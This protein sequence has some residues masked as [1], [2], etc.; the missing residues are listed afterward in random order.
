MRNK[1]IGGIVFVSLGLLLI[2]AAFWITARNI[3]ED[4]AANK[5]SASVLQEIQEEL[6]AQS[7]SE[8]A[9]DGDDKDS[10]GSGL[11]QGEGNFPAGDS[12]NENDI[13]QIE[14]P[15]Y[16]KNPDMEMPTLELKGKDYIG[17]LEMP[18]LGI[19][20]PV[21]SDWSYPQLRIA[22]CRYK[23]SAY[24]DNLILMAHNYK[25][26]FGTLLEL[27]IGDEIYFTDAAGNVFLYEV[28]E[29]ETLEPTAIEYMEAGDWDLTLFTCT[30]GGAA[31][32]TVRC[33]RAE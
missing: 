28:V 22:P 6:A 14:I 7:N 4:I 12:L 29:L 15:E 3:Y 1:K 2:A 17:V 11:N 10:V 16:L 27:G 31:R 9:A 13:P 18:T 20:L 21:M 32:V 26:H 25:S 19:R 5:A 23:G 30:V 24:K 33:E 8:E